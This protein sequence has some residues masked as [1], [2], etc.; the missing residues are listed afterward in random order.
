MVKSIEEINKRIEKGEAVVYSA[1]ELKGLLREGEDVSPSTVDVVTTA[2]CGI[3]SGTVAALTVPVAEKGAFRKAESFW[4]NGVPAYPGPCPNESLGIVDVMLY[5]TSYA[6]MEYGGGH[7]LRDLVEGK[8]IEVRVEADGN[9]FEN[10]VTLDDLVYSKLLTTRGAFKNYVAF[11]NGEPEPVKTI[12]SVT[13]L[14]GPY[15]EVSVS[16]CG[17]VN[18]IENDPLLSTIGVGTRILLNGGRGYVIGQGTR[19]TP[20][21]PNLSVYGDLRG[22]ESK[23]MGGFKTSKTPECIT[24]V[25]VPIPVTETTM[26]YLR[27]FDDDIELPIAEIHNRIPFASG[28]YGDVWQ[29]TDHEVRYVFEKCIDCKVCDVETLCPTN[30]FTTKRGIDKMRC[31]N[32][33]ACVT[34]C[35]GGAFVGLCWSM[36]I[37]GNDVPITLRQSNRSR[38]NQL[39]KRLQKMIQNGKFLLGK[40]MD[41]I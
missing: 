16:G 1:E 2:T 22:M 4:L 9:I 35:P 24:S 8:E 41:E 29:D 25:A 26:P 36:E 31:Y 28:T 3:M 6:N 5:G 19:S 23:Y 27:V 18:P 13:G 15:K 21:K 33:G 11:V 30:A 10:H 39:A 7:V 17:E 38:A 40:K 34:I 37:E 12:F 32:C 14:K 20:E